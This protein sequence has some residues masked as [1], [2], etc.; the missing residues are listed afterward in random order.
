MKANFKKVDETE[1]CP[2]DRNKA[3]QFI[4]LLEL[5]AKHRADSYPVSFYYPTSQ[6][7][8]LPQHHAPF[9]SA[10][11]KSNQLSILFHFVFQISNSIK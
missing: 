6:E 2:S 7:Y 8:P 4:F 5:M 10:L 1:S 11:I 9:P 3:R